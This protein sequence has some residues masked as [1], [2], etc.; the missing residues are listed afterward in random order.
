MLESD[1]K[2]DRWQRNEK[3]GSASS[4]ELFKL[5]KNALDFSVDDI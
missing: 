3:T 1:W 4:L 2:V 5:E